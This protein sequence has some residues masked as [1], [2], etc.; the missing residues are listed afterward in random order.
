MVYSSFVNSDNG[1]SPNTDH[2]PAPPIGMVIRRPIGSKHVE[3]LL[4][5]HLSQQHDVHIA[6][7]SSDSTSS[8]AGEP[9][10][11]VRDELSQMIYRQ[12]TEFNE[13]RI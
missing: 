3:L 7:R 11:A 6:N 13:I 4:A 1:P 8:T 9:I 12:F 5:H 2:P 10:L